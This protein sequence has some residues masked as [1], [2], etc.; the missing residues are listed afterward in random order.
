MTRKTFLTCASAVGLA[1]G[2]FAIVAP[3]AFLAGKGVVHDDAAAVWMREVGVLIT[4]LSVLDLLVRAHPSSPTLRAV[5]L[6]NAL[7]HVGLFPVEL[8][9]HARGVIPLVSGVVPN[10]ILH[11]LLAGG[12]LWFWRRER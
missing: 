5:L 3:A 2:L 7:V 1:V 10:S 11:V 8:V 12:A 4:A 6:V 9:A